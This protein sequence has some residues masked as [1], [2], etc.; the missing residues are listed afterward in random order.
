MNTKESIKK[1]MDHV[2]EFSDYPRSEFPHYTIMLLC[3]EAK[4]IAEAMRK[5][6]RDHLALELGD[7]LFSIFGY[8]NDEKYMPRSVFEMWEFKG[9]TYHAVY[10]EKIMHDA[11]F[12]AGRIHKLMRG[13]PK[14]DRM[15]IQM[16]VLGC[17]GSIWVVACDYGFTLEEI[18]ELNIKKL[19]GRRERDT[20]KGDGDDR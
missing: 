8:L 9:I 12:L 16:A 11:C 19:Q 2:R 17:L 3:G 20:L 15:D 1:Y 7:A 13:D 18:A 14:V 4:E 6:D 5:G 10:P